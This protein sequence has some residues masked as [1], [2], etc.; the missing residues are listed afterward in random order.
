MDAVTDEQP[1]VVSALAQDPRAR[2]V[3]PTT[4]VNEPSSKDGLP[5]FRGHFPDRIDHLPL[6]DFHFAHVVEGADHVELEAEL[7]PDLAAQGHDGGL[8]P[9]PLAFRLPGLGERPRQL[10]LN[11]PVDAAKLVHHVE[12]A[13][14]H[15]LGPLQPDMA[16]DVDVEALDALRDCGLGHAEVGRGLPLAVALSFAKIPSARWRLTGTLG[17]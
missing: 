12:T 2:M 1:G 8:E 11:R 15:R 9:L 3:L 10:F 5:D 4:M 14:G 17:R 6:E 16:G 13:L 7:L